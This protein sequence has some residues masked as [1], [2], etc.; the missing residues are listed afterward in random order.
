M[1]LEKITY[2]KLNARQKE[3]FNFQKV[4][5]LLAD[6]GFNCMKL[7][8]DWQ[9]ADF[10]AYH[11]DGNQTLKVQ[12]KSRLTIEK[13]YLRK[14]IFMAFPVGRSW[15]LIEHDRLVAIVNKHT[16]WLKSESWRG[17]GMY[18]TSKPSENL[19]GAIQSAKL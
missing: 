8:D 12:L 17:Q 15:Y 19:V 10:L 9:G 1:K 16:N 3:N 5:G 13:K 14:N 4:A 7:V 2:S 6:Y 18:S 11:V